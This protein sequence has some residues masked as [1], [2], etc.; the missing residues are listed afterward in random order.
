MA[1]RLKGWSKAVWIDRKRLFTK[2]EAENIV[3]DLETNSEKAWFCPL[4]N[5]ECKR[6]DCY[7]YTPSYVVQEEDSP[8]TYWVSR[9]RCRC[10]DSTIKFD[11]TKEK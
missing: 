10:L 4:I 3:K 9:N 5:G 6:E 11:S 7:C 2:E 8:V 1:Q